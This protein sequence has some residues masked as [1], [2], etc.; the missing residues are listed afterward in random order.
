[1]ELG[2]KGSC[3][4]GEKRAESERSHGATD[5]F[6]HAKKFVGKPLPHGDTQINRNGLNSYVS[7]SQ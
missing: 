7:V 5:R 6:R 3:M 1:M 2:W 4:L